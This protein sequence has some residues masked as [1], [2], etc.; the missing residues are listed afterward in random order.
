V[1]A[2]SN[3]KDLH[4]VGVR[5]RGYLKYGSLSELTRDALREV[6]RCRPCFCFILDRSNHPSML[7]KIAPFL[8]GGTDIPLDLPAWP[9]AYSVKTK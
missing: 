4:E 7:R 2:A 5:G 1:A 8:S 9:S 6:R 3:S